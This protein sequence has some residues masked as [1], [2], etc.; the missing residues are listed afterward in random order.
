MHVTPDGQDYTTTAIKAP[1]P[2]QCSPSAIIWSLGSC[3]TWRCARLLMPDGACTSSS[4][5]CLSI[6]GVLGDGLMFGL[7]LGSDAQDRRAT[8]MRL[9]QYTFTWHLLC[10][11][12][13]LDMGMRATS[14]ATS[15][16]GCTSG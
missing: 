14:L 10:S 12:H 16:P 8:L 11:P 3:A 15:T 13:S 2:A 6:K 5:T 4:S 7:R 9:M 1:F